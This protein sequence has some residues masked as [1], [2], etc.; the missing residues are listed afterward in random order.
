MSSIPQITDNG[1]SVS[2]FV[3]NFM[4]KFSVRKLLF[5]CNAG[6]EKGIPVM[7]IFRYLFCMMFSD[8]SIYMQMKTDTF[9]ARFSKNTIYRFLNSA[10]TNWQRFTTLLFAD[11]ICK[12]MK[13]LTSDGR[14]DVFI[15]DDS[16]FDRSR[17]RKGGDARQGFRPLLHEV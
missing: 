9:N 12:F 8:R 1:N 17:S 15:V 10:K 14:K 2:D 7:D 5:K 3:T 6:K 16:L 13:P 4:K 11:V